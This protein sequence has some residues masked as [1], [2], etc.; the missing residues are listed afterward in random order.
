MKLF[1]ERLAG[2]PDN[3]LNPLEL[4]IELGSPNLEEGK[5]LTRYKLIYDT[6]TVEPPF[7]SKQLSEIGELYLPIGKLDV[8]GTDG[9][10]DFVKINEMLAAFSSLQ[11]RMSAYQQTETPTEN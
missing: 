1:V 2:T 3:G 11:L 4:D 7:I 10:L 9:K 5:V 8:K 6:A